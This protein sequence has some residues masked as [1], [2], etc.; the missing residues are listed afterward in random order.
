M[1]LSLNQYLY[2]EDL[3]A[4]LGLNRFKTMSTAKITARDVRIFLMD[5]PALNTLLDGVRWSDEDIDR[6]GL[7][8]VDAFNC[9]LPPTGYIS[10]VESFPFRYLLLIGVAGHLLR[11]AA[12]GE[13]SNALSYQ[14]D[15]VSVADRDKAQVFSELGNNFWK[16]FLDMSKQIKLAANVN[17]LLGMTG[18][19]FGYTPLY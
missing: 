2:L 12:V 5:T 18:S 7:F 4:K 15:G 3:H 19:E 13:A 6:A 11:G 9:Q 1:R 17:S 8:V 14:A 16:E 10:S